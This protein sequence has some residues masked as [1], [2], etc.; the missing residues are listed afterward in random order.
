MCKIVLNRKEQE[1]LILFLQ[2]RFITLTI[3]ITFVTSKSL[4]SGVDIWNLDQLFQ[5]VSPNLLTNFLHLSID[6]L[7][8]LPSPISPPTSHPTSQ[9]QIF[10]SLIRPVAHDETSISD[11]L[12]E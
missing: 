9:T 8:S 4:I 7:P 5:S 6:T 11:L 1:F 3:A 12:Q 10:F 2:L